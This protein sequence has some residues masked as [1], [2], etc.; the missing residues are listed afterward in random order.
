MVFVSVVMT[1]EM[2]VK[3]LSRAIC[4]AV[5]N[6]IDD[7]TAASESSIV[8][9]FILN[10]LGSPTLLCILGSRISFNLKEAAEH[11][12]N[13]GTNQSSRPHSDIRFG[14]PGGEE[15]KYVVPHLHLRSCADSVPRSSENVDQR[16]IELREGEV[17]R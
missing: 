10:A 14:E 7:A 12:I 17:K 4:V 2:I 16:S 3:C 6:I 15:A 13:V 8:P 11:G 1:F 5:F 9:A